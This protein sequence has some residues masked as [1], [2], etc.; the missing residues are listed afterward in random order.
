V[1][2]SISVVFLFDAARKSSFGVASRD[3]V[4][5]GHLSCGCVDRGRV[6]LCRFSVVFDRLGGDISGSL[7]VAAGN[8]IVF[9]KIGAVSS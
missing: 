7:G 4:I 6:V 3:C 2:W 9:R 5:L 1:N 8:R